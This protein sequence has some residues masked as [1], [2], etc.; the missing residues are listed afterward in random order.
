MMTDIRMGI[1]TRRLRDQ[2]RGI[3]CGEVVPVYRM[4]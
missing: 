4:S 3:A 1:P 2:G